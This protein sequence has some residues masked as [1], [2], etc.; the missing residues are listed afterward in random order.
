LISAL[1]VPR[2]NLLDVTVTPYSAVLARPQVR[3]TL[4][5]GIFIRIPLWA[6]NVLV[7][8]HVVQT[9]GRSYAEAGLVTLAVT[10]AMAVSGPVRGRLLDR[11]GLRATLTPCL[12]VVA[13]C[14]SIAPF[15]GFVPLLLLVLVAG[16]FNLPIFP[17]IRQSLLAVSP[18]EERRSVLSLDSV[19]TEISFMI[20]PV[21]G[22]WLGTTIPTQWGLL[23]TQLAGVVAGGILWWVNPT[24]TSEGSEGAGEAQSWRSWFTRG[25]LAV[26]LVTAAATMVLT[27]TEIGLVALLRE[28]GS[29]PT[30][31]VVLAVWGLGSAVGGLVY[32]LLHRHV[33]A[34]VL[35]LLLGLV[36]LPVGASHAIPVI[37]VLA[38]VAGLLCA[39][40]ITAT[41]EQ[42]SD[43]VE[44]RNRGEAFG[45]H[46]SS[47]TIGS[48]LGAPIA[49][50]A[51]DAGGAVAGFVA[52]ALI[53]C[54]AA[55]AGGIALSARRRAQARAMTC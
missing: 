1:S 15:V 16:Y 41:V 28:A 20:G 9:L 37:T 26:F 49:G 50:A 29:T 25:V 27:G 40:T 22:V 6:A 2:G 32:G 31:G 38:G 18:V 46:G 44:E 47:M 10:L 54:I 19:A 35:L 42:L 53:G 23:I 3:Q 36:T 51:I 43:L 48:A 45:W 11:R 30:L 5:L 34:W 7:T 8:L 33:P 39:P 4:L 52:V 14:W 21:I 13:L 17:I 12:V 55:A 24:M